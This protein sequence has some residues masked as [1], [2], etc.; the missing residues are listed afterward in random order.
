MFDRRTSV[1]QAYSHRNAEGD[2]K[3]PLDYAHIWQV[4]PHA[5]MPVLAP[6]ADTAPVGSEKEDEITTEGATEGATEITT[7]IMTEGAPVPG[8]VVGGV[9]LGDRRTA[10]VASL[11]AFGT[12]PR[13]LG[14]ADLDALVKEERRALSERLAALAESLG[15]P[16]PAQV[17]VHHATYVNASVTGAHL[18]V[19]ET[20]RSRLS[21]RTLR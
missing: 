5:V 20:T 7:E 11:D 15:V 12:R 6:E 3:P 14:A 8:T 13:S 9:E 16:A 17:G 1:A 18:N 4:L 2:A 19:R 21:L 10:V